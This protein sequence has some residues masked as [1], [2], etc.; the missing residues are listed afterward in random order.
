M[1]VCP[2]VGACSVMVLQLPCWCLPNGEA[3]PVQI[4]QQGMAVLS[5]KQSCC[6][7]LSPPVLHCW[8]LCLAL[9]SFFAQQNAARVE[10]VR[11]VRWPYIAIG[12][13]QTWQWR[14]WVD[15]V[16]CEAL[17]GTISIMVAFSCAD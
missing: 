3:G 2:T 4:Q 1:D 5:L 6:V 8:A 10:G 17:A 9:A 7:A 12:M 15:F 11:P 16:D 13:S 14:V